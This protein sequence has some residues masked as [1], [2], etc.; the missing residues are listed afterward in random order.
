MNQLAKELNNRKR[1]VKL[2]IYS[3]PRHREHREEKFGKE[4]K[5]ISILTKGFLAFSSQCSRWW[6]SFLYF[7]F[8]I[9]WLGI[10]RNLTQSSAD[11]TER[12]VV[13][14]RC[15]AELFWLG[16]YKEESRLEMIVERIGWKIV[17]TF[18]LFDDFTF[19]EGLNG[20][21]GANGKEEKPICF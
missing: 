8:E 18:N 14:F 16:L 10:L 20:T 11:F 7:L 21:F 3:P 19:G 2:K 6:K 13:K 12:S 17:K 4:H 9:I 1:G 5:T 15:S